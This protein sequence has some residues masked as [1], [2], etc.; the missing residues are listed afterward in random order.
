MRSVLAIG[1]IH[2]CGAAG[3]ATSLCYHHCLGLQEAGTTHADR[4]A[5]AALLQQPTPLLPLHQ[6]AMVADTLGVGRFVEEPPSQQPARRQQL[7]AVAQR[8]AHEGRGV[9]GVGRDDE[10]VLSRGK[11][12]QPRVSI[13]V[14]QLILDKRVLGGKGSA[15]AAQEAF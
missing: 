7:A 4:L 5:E 12:L 8:V 6:R 9:Q 2:A 11:A 13:D 1:A 14:E 15:C 3:S 10:V